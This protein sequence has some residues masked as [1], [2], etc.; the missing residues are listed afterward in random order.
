[1]NAVPGAAHLWIPGNFIYRYFF[2]SHLLVSKGSS[3]ISAVFPLN[4]HLDVVEGSVSLSHSSSFSGAVTVIFQS[5]PLSSKS[6]PLCWHH[7]CF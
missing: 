2:L 4:S 3:F 6:N 7:F 5:K 1:M